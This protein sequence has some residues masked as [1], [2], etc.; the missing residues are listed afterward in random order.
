MSP[1]LEK[2]RWMLELLTFNINALP[3]AIKFNVK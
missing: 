1:Q 2:A 3:N